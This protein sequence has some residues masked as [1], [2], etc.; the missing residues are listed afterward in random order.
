MRF[1][2]AEEGF[3]LSKLHE[4]NV[5]LASRSNW[6]CQTKASSVF[7]SSKYLIM[8]SCNRNRSIC[9][10]RRLICVILKEMPG[11]GSGQSS[12]L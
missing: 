10:L 4:Q 7:S 9:V 8:R 2:K 3:Y 5:F 12:K 1:L 6:H 11:Q